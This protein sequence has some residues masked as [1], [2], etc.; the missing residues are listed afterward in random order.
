LLAATSCSRA[1]SSAPP[2]YAYSSACPGGS[3][4]S[5]AWEIGGGL[6]AGRQGVAVFG[7]PGSV[8]GS[9]TGLGGSFTDSDGPTYVGGVGVWVAGDELDFLGGWGPVGN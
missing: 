9:T 5:Y 3:S 2:P 6:P 1:D 8:F 7:M 4:A